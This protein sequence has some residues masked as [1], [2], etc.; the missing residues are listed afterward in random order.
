MY[1]SLSFDRALPHLDI[2]L[3]CV[4]LELLSQSARITNQMPRQLTP[5]PLTQFFPALRMCYV[6]CFFDFRVMLCA[7]F[8]VFI[9]RRP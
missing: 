4:Y 3:K 5:S 9:M 8:Q 7:F 6:I 2:V 1:I